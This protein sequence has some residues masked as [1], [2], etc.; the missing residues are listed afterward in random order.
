[1]EKKSAEVRD[2]QAERYE[3]NR[4]LTEAHERFEDE[5]NAARADSGR[6]QGRLEELQFELDQARRDLVKKAAELTEAHKQRDAAHAEIEAITGIKKGKKKKKPT[7]KKARKPKP[8][9]TPEA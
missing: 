8:K 6:H 4:R 5:L 7:T 2:A 1:V 3:S 9:P